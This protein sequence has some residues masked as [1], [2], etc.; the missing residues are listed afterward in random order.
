MLASAATP[1]AVT[2]P[3]LWRDR[4]GL[5]TMKRPEKITT[6]A[7]EVGDTDDRQVAA[8]RLVW[9]ARSRS[10]GEERLNPSRSG[11]GGGALPTNFT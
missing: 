1:S 7:N 4:P 11:A 10:A 6:P 5:V 2:S 9:K 3:T 8:D